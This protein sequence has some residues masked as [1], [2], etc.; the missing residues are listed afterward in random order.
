[1]AVLS[2]PYISVQPSLPLVLADIVK[3]GGA[4]DCWVSCYSPPGTGEAGPDAQQPPRNSV[5]GRFRV[6]EGDEAGTVEVDA[7]ANEVEVD[8]VSKSEFR[9]ACPSLAVPPTTVLLPC[10]ALNTPQSSSSYSTNS[11]T[12]EAPAPSLLTFSARGGIDTFALSGDGRRVVL[13]GRDGQA[14]VVEV[15]HY[16]NGQG[17][18]GKR[19][20]KGKETALRGHQGDLT[21]VE[22]FPSNEVVLTASSDMSLR[23]FSAADGSSPRHLTGHTKRVTGL[24]ILRSPSPSGPHKGRLVLSS[25]LDGTVKLWEVSSASVQRT[26]VLAQPVSAMS[27]FQDDDEDE[28]DVLK[29]KHALAAHSDGSVSLVDLSSAESSA[30]VVLKTSSVT[31]LDTLSVLPLLDGRRAITV[32]GRNGLVSLFL[33]PALPLPAISSDLPLKPV[34]EWRRT[35]G[36]TQINSVV[37]SARLATSSASSEAKDTF[38]VLVA[39]SDGLAYRATVTLQEGDEA[40]KVKV[41]EEFVGLDCE[42]ATGVLEDEE[43]KVWISGGGGD[44]ELRV[45]ERA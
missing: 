2:L 34:A 35:E 21:A 41:V 5:H 45:Y 27:V 37:L 24:S 42:P 43:G 31:S 4:E 12:Q 33:L 16:A 17:A 38:S 15:V 7:R 10:P 26:W 3:D 29:G 1:M 9:V 44:G 36:G 22:F 40:P 20:G 30:A 13:G 25:S 23:L 18:A 39:P 8:M 11:T 6:S 19:L 14:K 28:Q 32:G